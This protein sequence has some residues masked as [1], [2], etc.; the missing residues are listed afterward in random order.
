MHTTNFTLATSSSNGASGAK[1]DVKAPFEGDRPRK[2]W[3]DSVAPRSLSMS[4]GSR[5]SRDIQGLG[6]TVDGRVETLS[7]VARAWPFAV[8]NRRAA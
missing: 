1:L 8:L 4:R 6:R 3:V 5:P 7:G 2:S